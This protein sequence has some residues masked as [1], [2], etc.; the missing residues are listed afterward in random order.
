M[1]ALT[2]TS[3]WQIYLCV[4]NQALFLQGKSR[5]SP[6]GAQK[7]G[8]GQGGH[9]ELSSV[10]MG[11]LGTWGSRRG[12]CLLFPSHLSPR[13]AHPQFNA[14]QDVEAVLQIDFGISA[15][16]QQGTIEPF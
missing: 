6:P 13:G 11:G 14:Q 4:S 12:L 1:A 3:K 8:V 16:W 5:N 7:A 15:G 10:Q 9:Q 2:C